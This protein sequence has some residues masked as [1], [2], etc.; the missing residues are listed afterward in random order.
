M[1]YCSDF[2][3]LLMVTF[4]SLLATLS[5]YK[6]AVHRAIRHQ[7]TDVTARD[8]T[9]TCNHAYLGTRS[10]AAT[11][12][13]STLGSFEWNKHRPWIRIVDKTCIRS[14]WTRVQTFANRNHQASTRAVWFLWVTSTIESRA[15]RLRNIC[16]RIALHSGSS[17]SVSLSTV[18][19]CMWTFNLCET[20]KCTQLKFVVRGYKHLYT[21]TCPMQ[22]HLC[23]AHSGSPQIYVW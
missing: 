12:K 8:V 6:L 19:K 14:S 16:R 17:P 9:A 11:L 23:G 3:W 21:H 13:Y 1:A 5:L 22:S 2:R 15:D 4:S 10:I 20:F 7:N 18:L